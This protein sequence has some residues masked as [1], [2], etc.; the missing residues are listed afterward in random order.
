[1]TENRGARVEWSYPEVEEAMDSTG[2]HPI[3]VY[4][5]RRQKK[6]PERVACRPVYALCTEAERMPGTIRMV[7]WWDQ[8]VVN[9]TE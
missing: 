1:M 6:T 8:D 3:R 4:I 5:N 7:H 9:D 2:L